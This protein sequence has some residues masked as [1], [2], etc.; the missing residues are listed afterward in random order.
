MFFTTKKRDNKTLLSLDTVG[1]IYLKKR[2]IMK[3]HK[4]SI[5]TSLIGLVLF[6]HKKP[7]GQPGIPLH[8]I[9][10]S[11]IISSSSGLKQIPNNK[12]HISNNIQIT[13][14]NI[15]LDTN[16]HCLNCLE[17]SYWRLRFIWDLVLGIWGILYPILS[18]L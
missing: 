15:R 9:S 4:I 7:E 6:K 13:N 5:T 14:T 17:I 18:N 2:W 16:F 10:S 3:I 12:H 1:I 8:G 11:A